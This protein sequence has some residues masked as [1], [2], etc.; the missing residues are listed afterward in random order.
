MSILQVRTDPADNL[1][2][3]TRGIALQTPAI[4]V[5]H[6]ILGIFQK[7]AGPR[8]RQR[9]LIT[10]H[11]ETV[12]LNTHVQRI[13]GADNGFTLIEILLHRSKPHAVPD[14]IPPGTQL[15]RCIQRRKLR[16]RRLEA[17]CADVGNVVT[18]YFQPFV[19]R[20]NTADRCIE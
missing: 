5:D 14:G 8:I 7:G 18:R 15:R 6:E 19:C 4:A 1:A 10:D 3:V 2:P 17:Q 20:M 16:T 12:A 13:T 11:E 9:A